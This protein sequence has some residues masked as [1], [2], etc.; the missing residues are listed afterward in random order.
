[1]HDET[2][3]RDDRTIE[4]APGITAERRIS[5]NP[6]ER[7]YFDIPTNILCE[8]FAAGPEAWALG[9]RPGQLV[10][11]A[12]LAADQLPVSWALGLF[13]LE[14]GENDQPIDLAF[15]ADAPDRLGNGE[16]LAP[17]CFQQV[18]LP[19]VRAPGAAG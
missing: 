2:P 3:D 4:V 6:V 5:R 15:T 9:P 11:P 12:Q 13:T 10:E 1:M 16:V 7:G 19:V 17:Q 18:E 8:Q 14:E